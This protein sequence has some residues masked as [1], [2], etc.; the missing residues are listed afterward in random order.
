MVKSFQGFLI[1]RY[2]FHT[3]EHADGRKGFNYRICVKGSKNKNSSDYYG[4][5]KEI[6]EIQFPG[7]LTMKVMI[8]KCD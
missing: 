1:N 5:L 2:R 3:S 4:V 7:Y 8:F 6:I